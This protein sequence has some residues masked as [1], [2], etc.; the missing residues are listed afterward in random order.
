MKPLAKTCVLALVALLAMGAG[1]CSLWTE[2]TH[3]YGPAPVTP[4]PLPTPDWVLAQA[5]WTLPDGAADPQTHMPRN[6]YS[7]GNPRN[8]DTLTLWQYVVSFH[9]DQAAVDAF[10]RDTLDT[11]R[12]KLMPAPYDSTVGPGMPLWMMPV[13][14]VP[15]G[16]L[17]NSYDIHLPLDDG[18]YLT[19]RILIT[20]PDFDTVYVS[21][22]HIQP[23][24]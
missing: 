14:A 7:T 3:P 15:K 11:T 8:G 17:F 20:A 5:G 18:T 6:L 12:D 4:D 22:A 1:G 16:S 13:D 23:G 2:V 24:R 9:A 21:L 19:P 10:L